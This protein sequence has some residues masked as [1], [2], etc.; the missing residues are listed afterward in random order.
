M[1]KQLVKKNRSYRRF[2]GTV[3]ISKK[4]INYL[5]DMARLCP[6]AANL[7]KLRYFFSI[8]KKTNETIFSHV[9]WAAYLKDWEGPLHGE[10]PTGYILILGPAKVSKHLLIDTGITAQTILLGATEMGLGGCQIASV[11]KDKL[12]KALNL[13]SELEIILVIALGKPV[14]IVKIE[15]VIDPDDIEYYR[16][17]FGIHH[18]PK[19]ALN[20]IIITT[21]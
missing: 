3:K 13:P 11:K 16:D 10:R 4:Q 7:Q 6:S 21:K 12:H 19:R 8:T 15:K 14:E 5:I 20:D 9:G 17:E 2:D 1:L 18:V